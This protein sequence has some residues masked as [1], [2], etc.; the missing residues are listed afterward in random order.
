MTCA[1]TARARCRD[2]AS[3]L[4]SRLCVETT[5]VLS[6]SI[7]PTDRWT[8]EVVVARSGGV[9]PE[10]LRDLARAGLSLRTAQPNGPDHYRVVAVA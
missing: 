2:A 1:L 8:L 4:E 5:D 9:P 6:P 3:R 10:V 7:D